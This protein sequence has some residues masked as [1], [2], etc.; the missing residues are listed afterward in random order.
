MDIEGRWRVGSKNLCIQKVFMVDVKNEKELR[1]PWPLPE[2]EIEEEEEESNENEANTHTFEPVHFNRP[3]W[4][5]HC[6]KFIYGVGKQG[7]LLV[8]FVFLKNKNKNKTITKT[9]QKTKTNIFF[10]VSY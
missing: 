1:M 3:T 8:C 4:C 7:L 10:F 5:G 6:T 2:I 9:T